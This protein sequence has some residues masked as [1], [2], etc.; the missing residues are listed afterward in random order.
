MTEKK[1]NNGEFRVHK[2]KAL[3]RAMMRAGLIAP[4]KD[5]IYLVQKRKKKK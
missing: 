4:K 5:I 1:I 3:D 2:L